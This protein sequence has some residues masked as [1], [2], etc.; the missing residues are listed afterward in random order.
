M[1][2]LVGDVIY[3]EIEYTLEHVTG[4]RDMGAFS[5]WM[6]VK[7]M[8]VNEISRKRVQRKESL[9]KDRILRNMHEER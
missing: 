5:P 7:V 3:Q 4:D 1:G 9:G 2:H 6:V 8:K